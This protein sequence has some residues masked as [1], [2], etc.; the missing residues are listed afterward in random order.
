[1]AKHYEPE[2][3][4]LDPQERHTA[5]WIFEKETKKGVPRD[6]ALNWAIHTAKAHVKKMCRNHAK[7]KV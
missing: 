7:S 4:A 6:E 2:F 5:Q 1:M 3:R